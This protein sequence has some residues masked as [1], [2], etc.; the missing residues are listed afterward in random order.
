MNNIEKRAEIKRL[1]ESVYRKR[2]EFIELLHKQREKSAEKS[3]LAVDEPM[4]EELVID[5]LEAVGPALGESMV[6]QPIEEAIVEEQV[7][8]DQQDQ[9]G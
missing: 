9:P 7:D 4:V 3:L 1:V 2:F 8:V 6:Q 5:E